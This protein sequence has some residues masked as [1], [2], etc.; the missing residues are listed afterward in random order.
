VERKLQVVSDPGPIEPFKSLNELFGDGEP[1][2]TLDE[3]MSETMQLAI[4]AVGCDGGSVS[5]SHEGS[6]R[7]MHATDQSVMEADDAQYATGLGPCVA[8]AT[9][10]DRYE[11]PDMAQDH[12]WEDFSSKA[13]ELGWRSSLSIPLRM[14]T[15][16]IGALNFYARETAAFGQEKQ[17]IAT[18]FASRAAI[19]LA[20]SELLRRSKEL[21]N[22]LEAA[23]ESRDV[24][25]QAKGILMEREGIT[26]D[27]AFHMLVTA[28][29]HSNTKLKQI[30][31]ELV[32]AHEH[33][34]TA[35]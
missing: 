28:S 6:L 21:V 2:E 9:T 25:G 22:Q 27:D 12:R 3:A 7:T 33:S 29:Q 24:I 4:R 31:Q 11:I 20:H 30:A 5:L 10:G 1:L 17:S 18:L 13:L 15:R 26:A 34:D 16:P 32:Q 8:A 19:S 14:E 23:L 35:E